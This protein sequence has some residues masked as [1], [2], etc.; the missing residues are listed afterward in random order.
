MDCLIAR[1][2][3]IGRGVRLGVRPKAQ[4]AAGCLYDIA[5]SIK[6]HS[7]EKHYFAGTVEVLDRFQWVHSQWPTQ[8]QL[9]G[10]A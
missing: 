1:K 4:L 10:P 2:N 6:Y 8:S 7:F 3:P 9:S 5:A